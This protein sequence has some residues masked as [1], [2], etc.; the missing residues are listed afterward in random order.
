MLYLHVYACLETKLIITSVAFYVPKKWPR[1][2]HTKHVLC[3]LNDELGPCR[4]NTG[5]KR[6]N[7]HLHFTRCIT[8]VAIR[9][10]GKPSNILLNLNAAVARVQL[11]VGENT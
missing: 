11:T 1:G 8:D 3:V 2:E 6:G 5:G 9:R 7:K 4:L 10:I